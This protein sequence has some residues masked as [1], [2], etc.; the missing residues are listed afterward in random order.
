M[1]E[2]GGE[3]VRFVDQ[4]SSGEARVESDATRKR[5]VV[6][7]HAPFI[8]SFIKFLGSLERYYDESCER[9]RER[10]RELRSMR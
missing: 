4:N 2:S 1:D 10:E 8:K 5:S 7:G 3:L 6:E 9:E